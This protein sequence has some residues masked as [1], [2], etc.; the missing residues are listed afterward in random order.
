MQWILNRKLS[1][2]FGD[3]TA[4]EILFGLTIFLLLTSLISFIFC[5]NS[6]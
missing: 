2:A 3:F 1:A 4:L 6:I 5:S